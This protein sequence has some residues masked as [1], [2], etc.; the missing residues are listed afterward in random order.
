M[1][2]E[3]NKQNLWIKIKRKLV[4][5]FLSEGSCSSSCSSCIACPWID[6]E[7]YSFEIK[8]KEE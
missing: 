5:V 2:Q 7:K 4:R 1:K 3:P 6:K 8:R